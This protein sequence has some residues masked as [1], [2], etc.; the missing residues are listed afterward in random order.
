MW[1]SVSY[2]ANV[3]VMVQV[4]LKASS[5]WWASLE[6]EQMNNDELINYQLITEQDQIG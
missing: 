5:C 6:I 3:V 4:N 1:E 2:M